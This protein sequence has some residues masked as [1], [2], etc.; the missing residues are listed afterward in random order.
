[1]PAQELKARLDIDDL[2]DED[3]GLYNTVAGLM[4]TL[5]GH[6]L[7]QGQG[8]EWAGWHFEVLALDGRRIDR[9]RIRRLQ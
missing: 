3:K 8:V 7:A 9:V 4:Q 2:P 5:S 6:L 1:M